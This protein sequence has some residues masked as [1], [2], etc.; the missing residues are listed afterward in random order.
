MD[1]PPDVPV[2]KEWVLWLIGEVAQHWFL[3]SLWL[4]GAGVLA[5][6]GVLVFGRGYKKRIAALEAR[7]EE[8]RHPTIVQNFQSLSSEEDARLRHLFRDELG[9]HVQIQNLK[10]VVAKLPQKPLGD[11][12]T[13]TELPE[14]ARI[15]T[16][17]DGSIRLAL[18]VRIQADFEGASGTSSFGPVEVQLIKKDDPS[19]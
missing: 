1:V 8:K 14:G 18:P 9:T 10:A 15:V 5:L 16:K 13:Y 17:A 3:H 4:A 7:L 12:Y 2:W 11:G 19:E 6:L